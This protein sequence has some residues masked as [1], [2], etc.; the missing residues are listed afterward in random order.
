MGDELIHTSDNWEAVSSVSEH[1]GDEGAGVKSGVD[2]DRKSC[3]ADWRCHEEDDR[4]DEVVEG[5]FDDEALH[6][7]GVQSK[8][9]LDSGVE[10]EGECGGG[11]SKNLVVSGL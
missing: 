6:E 10:T 7:L 11:G 9:S 8:V 1:L 4:V 2:G 5:V 3:H